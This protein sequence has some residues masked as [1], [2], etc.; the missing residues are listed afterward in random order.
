MNTEKLSSDNKNG[1][2]TNTMLA[3]GRFKTDKNGRNNDLQ[4]S[5]RN[6]N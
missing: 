5:I 6:Y 2:N 1:N 3:T 4:I